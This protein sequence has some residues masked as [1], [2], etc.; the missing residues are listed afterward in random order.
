MRCS[1][2]AVVARLTPVASCRSD[3]GDREDIVSY[4]YSSYDT[5]RVAY[6]WTHVGPITPG[7]ETQDMLAGTSVS[8]NGFCNDGGGGEFMGTLF[9]ADS[10]EGECGKRH[11]TLPAAKTGA[12]VPDNSCPS[13]NNGRCEDGLFWS[14]VFPNGNRESDI[15]KCLPNTGAPPPLCAPR[16]PAD[17]SCVCL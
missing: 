7:G 9:G 14:V 15:D 8:S 16:N 11:L 3:C 10:G 6:D 1:S 2:P 4:G 5:G 12:K 17:T 13:A